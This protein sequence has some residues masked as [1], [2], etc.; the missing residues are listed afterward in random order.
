MLGINTFISSIIM[1][2]TFYRLELD[3]F[4]GLL[5]FLFAVVYL[6]MWKIVEIKF[7]GEKHAAALFYL[8]GLTFAVLV[9]PFQFGKAW[10]SLGW[11]VEGVL[12]TTYGILK[13]EK[14]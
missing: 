7:N 13:R 2:S 10:V 11:L 9:V 12:L 5:S 4:T 8:T 14:R 6:F 3:K 1:H